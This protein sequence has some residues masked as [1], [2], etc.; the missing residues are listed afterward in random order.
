MKSLRAVTYKWKDAHA[1]K[2]GED[3]S[4]KKTH[5]GFLAQ[6]VEAVLPEWV[7]TSDDGI[8]GICVKGDTALFVAAIQELL[9]RIEKLETKKA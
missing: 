3:K 1:E 5:I 9:A 7:T 4:N 8:K 2:V 6:E